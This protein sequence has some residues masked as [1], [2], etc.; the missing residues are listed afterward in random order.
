MFWWRSFIKFNTKKISLLLSILA[1]TTLTACSQ[2][3]EN[4]NTI[5][6]VQ[7]STEQQSEKDS[8]LDL[9]NQLAT[10]SKST[11]EIYVTGDLKIGKDEDINPGIYNL[12]ITGGSGNI[13][14]ERAA[15][16][17]LFINWVGAAKGSGDYPSKV[18][19]LLFEGDVLKLDNISKV[20]FNAVPEKV[21]PSNELGIGEFI[22][23]RDITAGDYKLSTNANLNPEYDN[24]G[25][26]IRIYN[27]SDGR[28]REQNLT[29]TN[30]D[31]AVS[32]KDGEVISI[33]YDNTDYGSSSDD[34]KL[35]FSEF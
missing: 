28:S 24:L 9:L 13:F 14:G 31:V 20:K 21:E 5:H 27:D 23:G 11:E 3:A 2:N 29:A 30:N 26:S 12:E 17:S 32:L 35:I 8:P 18:R 7:E 16:P 15:V 1:I 6:E 33:S 10:L 25:W 19:I 4:D 34:A 22:V